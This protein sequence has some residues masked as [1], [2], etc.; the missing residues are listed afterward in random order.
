MTFRT[1]SFLIVLALF[2]ASCSSVMRPP[3][4]ASYMDSYNRDNAVNS[5]AFSYYAGQ[6]DNGHHERNSYSHKSH[7]EWWGDATFA[8]Y[9]SGSYFT[10]GWG[11]QT[12]TPFLQGGFVSPYIGLTGW[13]NTHGLF[14]APISKTEDK[15]HFAN[16]T[17]G[18][19][20]IEQIPINSTWKIGFTEHI[21]RNGRELYYV[22]E[23]G[24]KIDHYPRP[25]PKFYTEVGGGFYAT[26]PVGENAKISFEVRYGRDL[27][28]K[29]NRIAVTIDMWGFSGVIPIGGN[30]EMKSRSK[31]NTQKMKTLKTTLADTN[32]FHMIKRHWFHIADSS[33]TIS[34]IYRPNDSIIAVTSKGICYNDESNT[35]W[36][37]QD[38]GKMLY[39]ISVDSLDYCQQMERKNLLGSSILEGLLLSLVGIQVTTNPIASLAIG[40]G[41]GV[42]YWAAM[43]FRFDPEELAPKVYPELC[44]EK[45]SK[46]QIIE[47]LKQYPCS[48]DLHKKILIETTIKN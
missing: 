41:S 23:E 4:A 6:L 31:K 26:R 27:D 37:K 8:R 10:F 17:G 3:P 34:T 47:W 46:E 7:A 20:L 5:V 28:E 24:T 38:Y 19:M 36:L 11:L 29:R 25:R 12:W 35:V 40:V 48:G 42:G 9:I 22:D 32:S 45:H 1:K 44:S 30:D 43:N 21:S 13:A 2:L 14:W 33:Q 16:Y 39:Q 15:M 18:G